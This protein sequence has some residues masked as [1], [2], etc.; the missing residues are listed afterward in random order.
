MGPEFV[1]R[2]YTR[3]IARAV[4]D[5]MV[6]RWPEFELDLTDGVL[7]EV[8]RTLRA[9]PPA[10]QLAVLG[11]LYGIEVLSPFFGPG[12]KPLSFTDRHVAIQRMEA[13]AN[14]PVPQVRMLVMLLKVMISFAAYSRPD[15]E[16]FLGY[17]RREWRETRQAL[18]ARLLAAD[19][20]KLPAVPAPLADG[21]VVTP[22]DFLS[23]LAAVA[24]SAAE[25]AAG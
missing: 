8:E 4:V 25:Q 5:A 17:R 24:D 13:I 1:F 9:Y 14:H 6:P 7:D 15:V 19:P 22:A 3:R 16:A 21:R 18:R 10:I 23:F 2:G 20:A 11:S 12:L